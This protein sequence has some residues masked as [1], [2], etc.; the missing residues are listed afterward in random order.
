[1]EQVEQVSEVGQTS[2]VQLTAVAQHVDVGGV[3]GSQTCI[4]VVAEHVVAG[5]PPQVDGLS[6]V[7]D[8]SSQAQLVLLGIQGLESGLVAFQVAHG[9]GVDAS[10]CQQVHVCDDADSLNGV[11]EANGAV[12]GVNE[13]CI[14][15]GDPCF[16]GQV[17]QNASLAPGADLVVRTGD[18]DF[19][20]VVSLIVALQGAHDVD[21][22]AHGLDDDLNAGLGLVHLGQLLQLSVD[23]DLTVDQTNGVGAG[24]DVALVGLVSIG[25]GCAAA[26]G[27]AQDQSQSQENREKLFHIFHPFLLFSIGK[28]ET[29][30][31]SVHITT[32]CL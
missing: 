29:P 9:S 16:A 21:T 26:G 30:P 25:C 14:G 7:A 10:L 23:L 6:A 11:G 22:A 31:F 8:D 18:E 32:L 27:E 17:S 24:L 2:L 4:Q 12:L 15:V 13:C 19:G 28:L 3:G 1:M 5:G 20:H